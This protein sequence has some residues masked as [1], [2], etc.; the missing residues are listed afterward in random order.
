MNISNVV[1]VLLL[2]VFI[3]LQIFIHSTKL[4]IKKNIFKP[5]LKAFRTITTSY[6]VA[7]SIIQ[8]PYQFHP[9]PNQIA[10]AVVATDNY[11][12]FD[13]N[14]IQ[15]LKTGLKELN[16]LLKNWKEKTLY[17][18]FGEFQTDLLTPENKEK[19]LVAAAETGLLDYD[20]SKTMIVKC[21]RDPQMV[22][23]LLGLTPDNLNL[24]G[25]EKLMKKPSTIQLLADPDTVD[26]YFEQIEKFSIALTSA[27]SLSYQA[28][29]DYASTETT[30]KD[31]SES[32]VTGGGKLSYLDQS[33][34]SV[35][36]VRDALDRIVTLLQL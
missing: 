34:D 31:D 12:N 27:D 23:A 14:D 32:R 25:A 13:F 1:S 20:K 24:N 18:N 30:F 7:F 10:N 36:K 9:F 22:R 33:K 21:R 35:Q 8:S 15:R 11:E 16:Y 29:T 5:Y 26:E 2:G 6:A 28:R 17:C 4:S 19:L 3:N